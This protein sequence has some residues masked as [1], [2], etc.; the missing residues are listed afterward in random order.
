MIFRLRA[1]VVDVSLRVPGEPEAK[2]IDSST[3]DLAGMTSSLGLVC[4]LGE[5][6]T[7]VEVAGFVAEVPCDTLAVFAEK[8]VAH[9]KE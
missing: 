7:D 2:I 8:L 1:V 9:C 5:V 4:C 3:D 6:W